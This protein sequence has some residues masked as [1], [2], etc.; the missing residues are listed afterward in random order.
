MSDV[1]RIVAF[2]LQLSQQRLEAVSMNAA[3][4]TLPGYRRQ[5]I[6]ARAFD[7]ALAAQDAPLTDRAVNLRAGEL[8][9]T[10]RALD[11][12]IDDPAEFFALTDGT[13]TWLTRSGSFQV[14]AQGVLS[15]AGGLGVLGVTGELRVSASDVEIAADGSI[16][17][18]GIVLGQLQLFRAE[19]PASLRPARGALLESTQGIHP[20][21]PTEAR[22]RAGTLEA[23]NTDAGREMLDVM[24]LA[25]QYESLGRI[26]QGYDELLGRT[27][28]ML[29]EG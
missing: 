14:D 17:R 23:S 6:A 25:R 2:G 22:V 24:I 28:R 8:V 19:N 11:V 20:V 4:A 15:G 12:S 27:I 16:T 21:D 29:S 13:R 5:V 9:E 10:G 26:A 3:S 1:A 7:A 18:D